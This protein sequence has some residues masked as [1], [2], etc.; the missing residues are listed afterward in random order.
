MH[1]TGQMTRCQ[2][3]QRKTFNNVKFGNIVHFSGKKYYKKF[4]YFANF[5]GKN[6]VKF[7]HF[8]NFS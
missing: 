7:G 6:H 2:M 4:G 5:S 8:V 3:M 1:A